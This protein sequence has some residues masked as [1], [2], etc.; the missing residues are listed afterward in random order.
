MAPRHSALRTAI[1]DFVSVLGNHSGVDVIDINEWIVDVFTEANYSDIINETALLN[2]M[3]FDKVA[4]DLTKIGQVLKMIQAGMGGEAMPEDGQYEA[5]GSA[6]EDAMASM[7]GG[8]DKKMP[9]EIS[10]DAAEGDEDMMDDEGEMGDEEEDG[11]L[12][13]ESPEEAAM[14]AKEDMDGEMGGDDEEMGDEEGDSDENEVGEDEFLGYLEDLEGL[15]D[16]LK[17][18]MGEG[19]NEEMGDDEDPEEEG[20]PEGDEEGEEEPEG[21]ESPEE[22][23]GEED[24]E[25]DQK[26][27]F[28]AKKKKPFPPK[29]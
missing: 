18:K 22:E 6:G 9:D 5:D 23:M 11:D 1:E 8:E 14:G 19:G 15:I 21:E 28:P 10:D 7:S 20:M 17:S 4:S 29:E 27:K 2:Y 3:N 26:E 16:S 12:P 24:E 25:D 13:Q